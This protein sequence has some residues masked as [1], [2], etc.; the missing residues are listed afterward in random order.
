MARRAGE[1]PTPRNHL[2][3]GILFGLRLPILISRVEL[4]QCASTYG[5]RRSHTYSKSCYGTKVAPSRLYLGA[6]KFVW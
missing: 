5:A 6:V 1:H 2:E 3:A 4:Q